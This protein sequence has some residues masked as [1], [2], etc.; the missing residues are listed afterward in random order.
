MI[1]DNKSDYTNQICQQTLGQGAVAEVSATQLSKV[2]QVYFAGT[3]Q[4][5]LVLVC[6]F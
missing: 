5:Y 1:T 2:A 6:R 3:N 4:L